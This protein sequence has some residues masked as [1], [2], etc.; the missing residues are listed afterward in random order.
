AVLNGAIVGV[1]WFKAWRELNVL[2]FAFTFFIGSLWGAQGYRPEHFATTEPFLMLF[3]VLYTI[4]PILF[5]LRVPPPRLRGFVDGTLVFGTPL[6][7]FGL[8]STLVGDTEYGLAISACV[9][10]AYYAAL[11][12]AL[13]RRPVLRPLVEAFIALA[14]TSATLAIPLAFD[15][16]WTSAAWALEGTA[17]LWFGLRQRRWLALWSGVGLQI[18]A[19]S[20]YMAEAADGPLAAWLWDAPLIVNERFMGALILAAASFV[21]SAL[22]DGVR[23]KRAP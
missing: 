13:W 14:I 6:V 1:A 12:A 7:A 18:V 3:T 17:I 4:V 23:L 8:Q 19:A 22:L 2:G 20:A 10:A 5:A 9:L 11:A 15:A 16:G 21:A